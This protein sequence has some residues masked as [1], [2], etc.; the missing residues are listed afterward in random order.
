MGWLR[1][2]YSIQNPTLR[3]FSEREKERLLAIADDYDDFVEKYVTDASDGLTK[4][5]G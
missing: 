2:V 1:K 4:K 3:D 5:V